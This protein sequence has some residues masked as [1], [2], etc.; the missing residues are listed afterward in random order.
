MRSSSTRKQNES[1]G[2]DMMWNT[3]GTFFYFFCQWLLTILVVRLG[4]YTDAGIF[5]MVLSVS[6]LFY[7]ISAYGVRNYQVSDVNGKFSDSDYIRFRHLCSLAALLFFLAVLPF[8][9]LPLYT[10]VCSIVYLFYKFGDSYTDVLFGILQKRSEVKKIAVSYAL[11]GIISLVTFCLAMILTHSLLAA[12]L[13]NTIGIFAV[14]LLYDI[15]NEPDLKGD[16]LSRS[17]I[18]RLARDCF[19]LMLYSMLVPMLNF[20][21]RYDIERVFGTEELGYFSSV[22]MVLSVLNVLM[23]SVFVI[24]IP[25]I[26]RMYQ[27]R[28]IGKIYR[29]SFLALGGFALLAIIGVLL[30][31]WLGGPVFGLVFG[32]EILPYMNLLPGTV[33]ASVLLSAISFFSSVLTSLSKNDQVLYGNFPAVLICLLFMPAAIGRWGM[34][35]SLICLCAGFAVSLC[36]ILFFCFATLR[37]REKRQEA[38]QNAKS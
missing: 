30:G 24:L 29:L 21:M 8:L 22:T 37:K 5:S 16:K 36:V 11:K 23:V 7:C 20:I 28:E 17:K 26:T 32:K 1:V 6:N 25:K 19:P 27:K 4:S 18:R 14:I 12:L 10:A 35:G 9:R 34:N 38:S 15:K 3:I 33:I 31:N 13:V 2:S